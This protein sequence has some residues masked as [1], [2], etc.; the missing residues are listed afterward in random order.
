MDT[1]TSAV[2]VLADELL[3]AQFVAEPI[4]ATLLGVTGYDHKLSDVSEDGERAV[5]ARIQDIGRRAAEIDPATLAPEDAVT[6]AV[7]ERQA[8]ATVA[9]IDAR[10]VEHAITGIFISPAPGLLSM[11]PMVVLSDTE[12]AQAYLERLRAVPEF[13]DGVAQRHRAG[14]AA[15]R[16]PVERLVRQ[17]I[18]LLDRYLADPAADPLLRQPMPEGHRALA[19]ER[20]RLVADI[21]RPSFAAYR[22]MLADE[23]LQHGRP[24]DRPGVCWLPDGDATYLG[25]CQVHTTTDRTP[26]ELHQTGLDLIAALAD[27]YAEIG[28]RVFGT[29]DQREIFRRMATDPALRWTSG[30]ELLESAVQAIQRAQAAAPQWFGRLPGQ[31][32]AVVPVPAAE[33]PNAPAAYYMHPS[34]DGLRPGT[35]FANTDRADQR[36]RFLSEVIA[37]HEAVPGHHFQFTIAQELTH[38]PLLRRT[39]GVYPY[40]E[41]W[42]LYTE[43]LADEMGLYSSDLDRLGMLA[44]DSLRAGRLVV[45]TGVHAK[46]WSRQQA[47][48]YLRQNTPV[49]DLDIGNEVDRYIG[50]IGQALSYMVGRLEIQRMRAR[51]ERILGDRFD[52]RAF[53]DVVL[54]GGPLQLTVLDDVVS[55]WAESVSRSA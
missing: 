25:L 30:E 2:R 50:Y 39:A 22:D 11:L 7:I 47:V 54:G 27:E 12:K 1:Q 19:E 26:E 4:E 49:S 31:E 21:V 33:A 18:A 9:M 32:C 5:R 40:I 10:M 43:R 17:A 48:E 35:Y 24:D 44:M 28:S 41:G 8:E 14:V 29:S 15:G 34:L 42:G 23:M 6:R 51:A 3:E 36:D 53:H 52:I 38:L 45:D 20:Q 55:R 13:L 46:G 37:F 16:Y